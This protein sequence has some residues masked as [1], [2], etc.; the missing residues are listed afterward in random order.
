MDS[1][2]SDDVFSPSHVWRKVKGDYIQVAV[3]GKEPFVARGV[4]GLMRKQAGANSASGQGADGDGVAADSGVDVDRGDES[5]HDEVDSAHEDDQ[6]RVNTPPGWVSPEELETLL[7]EARELAAQSAREAALA[8][9]QAE[10][11]KLESAVH[12]LAEAVKAAVQCKEIFGPL[13]K[14][15]AMH[16]AE[17]VV[18][19]E[20]Q[21]PE[22]I[23]DRLIH[24][25]TAELEQGGG[26]SVFVQLNPDDLNAYASYIGDPVQPF[27]L[28][29][30]STLARGS[31]R[32]TADPS[33]LEDFVE[34]RLRL[35]GQQVLGPDYTP[36]LSTP[37]PV[38]DTS[39]GVA[40]PDKT[41]EDEVAEPDK[42]LEHEIAEASTPPGEN[43]E[44]QHVEG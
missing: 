9:A 36:D 37:A 32:V 6:Q 29:E 27:E 38:G 16:V 1:E 21:T 19:C 4:Q 14:K 44:G 20:L 22:R 18:R 24:A 23:I 34:R 5:L 25:C 43:E 42:T 40:E 12:A 33:T 39:P 15:L 31:V 8:E 26:L 41:L 13:V 28:R 7:A 11:I 3:A 10:Q 35:L 30:D 17:E 2:R